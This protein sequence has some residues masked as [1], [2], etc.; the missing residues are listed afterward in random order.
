MKYD[1]NGK[2]SSGAVSYPW[3]PANSDNA[4]QIGRRGATTTELNSATPNPDV[5][6]TSTSSTVT[7]TTSG[8]TT[9]TTSG[10][11]TTKTT[12]SSNT[13]G[14]GST[15]TNNSKTGIAKT[16]IVIKPDKSFYTGANDFSLPYM[17]QMIN[18]FNAAENSRQRIERIHVFDMVPNSFEFSQLS[19]QWNEVARAGNYPLVDWSNYN[20]TKVSFK[21]L[22]VAKRLENNIFYSDA[23]KN[24]V[25]KQTS[26]IVN[27]GLLSSIDE[28]LDNVR[29]MLGSPAPIRLYNM[30]NLL[31]TE[32]RYP[33]VNNTRN[34]EWVIADASITATRLTE[35]ASS[36]AAAEVSI[37]LTE[38]PVVARD[39]V[40]LPPLIPDRPHKKICKSGD[41]P[42]PEK[43]YA[44]F[45]SGY[46]FE[47]DAL[48]TASG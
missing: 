18:H 31:S 20:L 12:S 29:A 39:I 48:E 11:T 44:L 5:T 1:S 40:R 22:V 2:S 46:E 27:D 26:E 25:I 28:Q 47:R 37:T 19:S 14:G 45:T 33:Y 8:T 16:N 30:N 3:M 43:Q 9:S 13:A 23:T 15:T 10:T 7:G 6:A 41:C 34:M 17:K 4:P 21:F 36:I 24:K 35:N 42:E 32:Y 38:Y